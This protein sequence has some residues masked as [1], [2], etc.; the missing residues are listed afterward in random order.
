M[1]KKS[2][3]TV[4]SVALAVTTVGCALSGL[5][6]TW[7]FAALTLLVA[8]LAVQCGSAVLPAAAAAALTVMCLLWAYGALAF[9]LILMVVI[10]VAA[11]W[12]PDAA[13]PP[14]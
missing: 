1:H 13:E 3:L 11:L 2:L 9:I 8:H 10:C 5:A 14:Q 7:I 12:R 6:P 4:G